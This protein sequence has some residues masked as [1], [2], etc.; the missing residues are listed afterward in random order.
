MPGR[1]RGSSGALSANYVGQGVSPTMERAELNHVIFDLR[2]Q[3]T[4]FAESSRVF[5]VIVPL[6]GPCQL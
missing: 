3:L 2:H 4:L 1:L 6:T 5:L